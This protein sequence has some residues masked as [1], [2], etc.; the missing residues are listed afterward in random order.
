M[1]CKTA[2]RF[3]CLFAVAALGIAQ[4]PLPSAP[5]FEA[6]S[7]RSVTMES[8]MSPMKNG[9]QAFT[10]RPV[11]F[12][13]VRL[14]GDTS[15]SSYVEFACSPLLKPY[16][17]EFPQSLVDRA[18][19]YYQI[20]AIAPPGTTIDGARVMLRNALAERLG[21]QFHLTDREV[22]VYNLVRGSGELKLAPA[23]DTAPGMEYHR[24]PW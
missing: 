24:T 23:T 18:H 17:D 20:D 22:P 4:T 5:A 21:F 12:K 8:H 3:V 19:A 14:S 1:K 7:I 16:R 2:V 15:L 13:G 11:E 6:V 9:D 10:L